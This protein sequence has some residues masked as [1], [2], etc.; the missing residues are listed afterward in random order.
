MRRFSDSNLKEYLVVSAVIII[1]IGLIALGLYK[2]DY[3]VWNHG[4]HSNCGGNWVYQE[5]VGH[6]YNTCYIFRCDKCG[7]TYEFYDA[8]YA[9]E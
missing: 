9:R 8:N 7:E 2:H 1:I 3:S 4:H 5:A 6:K